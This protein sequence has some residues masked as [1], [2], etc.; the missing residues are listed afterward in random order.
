M[1][2]GEDTLLARR[3]ALKTLH[4][5]LSVDEGLRA[6]FRNEAVAAASLAHPS[7]VATYDTGEDAGVA[8]IVMELVEGPNL[9]TLLDERRRLAPADAVRIARGVAIALDQA[10]RN[11]I[12]HRDIKPANVLVPRE[13]PVKVTDFG[14]AKG[15]TTGDLTRT[16][17]ILGTARYLAPEQVSGGTTDARIRHLRARPRPPRV[18]RR[19]PAVPRRQRDGDRAR[20][21]Q[22]TAGSPAGGRPAVRGRDRRPL[23]HGRPGRPV[24]VRARAR[25]RARRGH[26]GRRRPAPCRP[27]EVQARSGAA[28]PTPA[29]ARATPAVEA[30]APASAAEAALGLAVRDARRDPAGSRRGGRLLPLLRCRG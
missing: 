10:H 25:R 26:G 9:R 8:Y 4:P 18:A 22:C 27:R 30:G 1:W 7:I 12:V 28:R 5:E 6:R 24:P 11:G 23:P 21:A 15:D 13:G 19:L 14:I 2:V 29:P 20:A 16:G 17:T 3:V